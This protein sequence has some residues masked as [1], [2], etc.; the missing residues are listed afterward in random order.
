MDGPLFR[1][2]I[3]ISRSL[4]PENNTT[5][6][7]LKI[8]GTTIKNTPR[9]SKKAFA[10]KSKKR[11]SRWSDLPDLSNDPYFLKKAEDARQILE[12]YGT[13]KK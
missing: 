3:I 2:G 11:T 7:Q 6:T 13:P 12:K 9:K 5:F 8:M 1:S 4:L 10:V